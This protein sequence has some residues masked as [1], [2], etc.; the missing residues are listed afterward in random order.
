[1]APK[2]VSAKQIFES[3]KEDVEAIDASLGALEHSLEQTDQI[4][5]ENT[6]KAYADHADMSERLERLEGRWTTVKAVVFAILATVAFFLMIR[7]A[8]GF[9]DDYQEHKAR[10]WREH[11]ILLVPTTGVV[12]RSSGIPNGWTTSHF[13]NH[14]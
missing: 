13:E 2:K 14:R 6:S 11:T 4:V 12:E 1:M 10:E 8:F 3:L 9:Y 5:N 7:G